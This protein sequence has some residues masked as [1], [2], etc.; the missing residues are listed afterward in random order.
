MKLKLREANNQIK[1]CNEKKTLENSNTIVETIRQLNSIH[2]EINEF[3]NNYWCK[4]LFFNK[5]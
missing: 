2:L 5:L 1:L 3:N 4:Y